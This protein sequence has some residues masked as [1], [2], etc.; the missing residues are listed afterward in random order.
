MVPVLGVYFDSLSED[1]NAGIR[2]CGMQED[3]RS[4]LAFR[5]SP[6][7]SAISMIMKMHPIEQKYI[8]GAL[9]INGYIAY[10]F[11]LRAMKAFSYISQFHSRECS[12]RIQPI[13]SSTTR[14]TP[15]DLTSG[16]STVFTPS[17]DP[18]QTDVS[19]ILGM[20]AAT[21]ACAPAQGFL[22]TMMSPVIGVYSMNLGLSSPLPHGK[23]HLFPYFQHMVLPDREFVANVFSRLFFKSLGDTPEN[24]AKL[25]ARLRIGFRS[26]AITEVGQAMSHAFMGIQL[27]ENSQSRVS[28]IIDAGVYHGFVITGDVTIILNGIVRNPS[29]PVDLAL[30]YSALNVKNA[31]IVEMIQL[32]KSEVDMDGSQLYEVTKDNFKSSRALVRYLLAIKKDFPPAKMDKIVK[33]AQGLPY[34]EN[35]LVPNA[36]NLSK[37]LSYIQT[38][39]EALIGDSPCYLGNG[40]FLSESRVA[41]ALLCFGPL[42]PSISFATPRD[43]IFIIPSSSAT[44]DPNMIEKGGKRSL[45][46]LPFKLVSHQTSTNQWDKVFN[47]GRIMIPNARKGKTEFSDRSKSD[48]TFDNE[49]FLDIYGKIKMICNIKRAEGGDRKRRIGDP[50]SEENL[51][52]KR[53][54]KNQDDDED[55][56]L[57]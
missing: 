5:G 2:R 13:D 24:C 17:G 48:G 1:D 27:A 36:E 12:I 37:I 55:A 9:P 11:A 52:R 56:M 49:P 53:A 18:V 15:Q 47:S 22:A 34:G 40:S 39:E 31:K 29:E 38:G 50:E 26:L 33:I 45:Q 32:V 54:R 41:R 8:P 7:P 44:S 16:P 30:D 14:T 43:Q 28:F 4:K 46:Y 57:V 19:T 23:G 21:M 25:W 6:P 35:F 42:S 51:V 3:P 10:I 20:T